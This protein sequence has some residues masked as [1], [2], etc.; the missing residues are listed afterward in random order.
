MATQ[1]IRSNKRDFAHSQELGFLRN[2]RR[3]QRRELKGRRF[4][5]E[6]GHRK[7]MRESMG[8]LFGEDV[9]DYVVDDGEKKVLSANVK[10]HEYK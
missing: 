8:I 4:S 3:K 9:A 6:R 10:C 1:K 2:K 7:D 5:M